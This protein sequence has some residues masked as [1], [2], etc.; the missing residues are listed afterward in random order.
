MSSRR[1]LPISVAYIGV[2]AVV[3]LAY[4]R[5]PGLSTNERLPFYL[6]VSLSSAVAILAGVRRHRPANRL[7][8]RLIAA[9]QLVYFAADVTFY[10]YHDILRNTKYPAP[11]D[12]LYLA[13]YPIL[14]AGLVLLGSRRRSSLLDTLIVG[15][16]FALLEW[17]LLMDP[18]V[19]PSAGSLMPRLTSLAYPVA[20]LLV[21]VSAIRLLGASL[22]VPAI[23]YLASAFLFLFFSDFAYAWLQAKGRYT[24]PGDFLDA[25]WMAYYLL[26]GAAALSPSM[27]RLAEAR[28]APPPVRLGVRRI[29]LLAAAAFTAPA[30][31]IVEHSRSAIDQDYAVAAAS[32]VV[33]A[34][35]ITRL[36]GVARAQRRDQAEK[37]RLLGRVVEAAE[38]ERIR[39]A[40]D[41]YDG[42][43]QKLFALEL[44]LDLLI[45]QL[46]RGE[47][48]EAA[49]S[50]QRIH[51]EIADQMGALRRLISNLRPPAIGDRGLARALRDDGGAI[52]GNVAVHVESALEVDLASELETVIYQIAREAF[53][54]VEAHAQARRVDVTLSQRDD[55]IVLSI[56]DDG[57]G[58]DGSAY[59]R[60]PGRFPGLTS[61]DDLARSL[62]GSLRI[63][64]GR[65]AGTEVRARF[66]LREK[67]D[68]G[69]ELS[70]VTSAG[71]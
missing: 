51:G 16:A 8:W 17:I 6:A 50:A 35:V 29:A 25:T 42:P 52:A 28:P 55:E 21:L 26:L 54:N 5:A 12:A 53:L 13:H 47:V 18:Y 61:M 62:G 27:R 31:L 11:A 69:S 49:G 41:I 2:G 15:T 14:A 19:H 7:P 63:V 1:S 67:G 45:A 30:T 24:G 34:L 58:F 23:A 33:F 9:S 46:G 60:D 65:G 59:A 3:A 48:D 68:Y 22:R 37:E 70:Q 56:R 57:L 38:R 66:P 10:T 71:W 44:R 32:I 64:S 36:A 4:F 39:F 20:D 40:A 43:V